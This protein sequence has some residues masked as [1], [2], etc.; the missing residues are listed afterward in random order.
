[1]VR[2]AAGEVVTRVMSLH[3]LCVFCRGMPVG[4]DVRQRQCARRLLATGAAHAAYKML[5]SGR[6]AMFYKPTRV[7]EL[8]PHVRYRRLCRAFVGSG[9]SFALFSARLP[10]KMMPR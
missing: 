7:A 1:V 2:V 8:C 5:I 4:V 9:H 10:G 6:Y 3:L